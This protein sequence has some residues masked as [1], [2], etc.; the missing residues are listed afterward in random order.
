MKVKK[1]L[2]VA[3]ALVL[4]SVS[5]LAAEVSVDNERVRLPI[6]GKQMTA[7]FLNITNQGEQARQLVSASAAWASRI[8][9]HTH[10][11]DNGVMRMRQVPAIDLPVG[12]TVM[13][14]PGGLHLMIFG[15]ESPLADSLAIQLCFDDGDCQAIQART[16]DIRK[17]GMGHGA[18][19]MNGHRM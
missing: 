6:P 11:N 15:I 18:G 7:G 17:E 12:E 9:L 19:H 2:A 14:Q 4:T 8:E 1:Y 3:T 5:T 13:L 10:V 16:V